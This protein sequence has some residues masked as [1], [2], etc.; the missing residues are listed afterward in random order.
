M[1]IFSQAVNAQIFALQFPSF[2]WPTIA[3]NERTDLA[4]TEL[5]SFARK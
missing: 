5:T 3:G 1:V 4:G 2:S